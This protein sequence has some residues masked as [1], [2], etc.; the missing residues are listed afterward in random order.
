M[1]GF[2]TDSEA[3]LAMPARLESYE[4]LR[5]FVLERAESAGLSPVI[6]ARLDLVLEELLVNVIS[7]AYPENSAG[8]V[9]LVCGL[10][11]GEFCL[12][13]TDNGTPFNPLERA[14]PDLSLPVEERQIGGLGIF[15]VR[16][17]AS[18]LEYVREDG[19]NVLTV[20]L[21]AA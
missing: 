20:C 21:S 13:I 14:A 8:A 12:R 16:E 5:A 2:D 18:R 9:E 17:M 10:S 1:T 6:L 3:I 11:R 19:R 15:L 7:Y 4:P